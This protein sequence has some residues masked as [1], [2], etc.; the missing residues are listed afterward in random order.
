MKQIFKLV[1]VSAC[2]SAMLLGACHAQSHPLPTTATHR[3]STPVNALVGNWEGYYL[4]VAGAGKPP[5][6]YRAALSL[7]ESN[8]ELQGSIIISDP[9]GDYF[10][11]AVSGALNDDGTF[12]LFLPQSTFASA[13]AQTTQTISAKRYSGHLLP[14]VRAIEGN[15]NSDPSQSFSYNRI[16]SASAW[17][18]S[19]DL[20]Q[21]G[22]VNSRSATLSSLGGVYAASVDGPGSQAYGEDNN[23]NMW[24]AYPNV[25]LQ[26]EV[27][28]TL[29]LTVSGSSLSGT[30][31][32][33]VF[34]TLQSGF[35]KTYSCYG[36]RLNGSDECIASESATFTF[37]IEFHDGGTGWISGT[38]KY[39][40]CTGDCDQLSSVIGGYPA[41]DPGAIFFNVDL[42]KRK[43]VNPC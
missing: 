17:T 10:T 7:Q 39:Q 23:G 9:D 5:I 38:Q 29:R 21:K 8:G 28:D 36:F 27:A 41:P 34:R 20:Y 11:Q 40:G 12:S 18:S 1:V 3:A 33:Q 43:I 31:V 42:A 30:R 25:N 26:S 15:I 4:W 37:S 32:M 16:I 22:L 14:G 35:E 2:C 13:A 19:L 24:R 6:T